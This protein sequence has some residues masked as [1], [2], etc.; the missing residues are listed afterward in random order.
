MIGDGGDAFFR[1]IVDRLFDASDGRRVD[2]DVIARMGAQGGDQQA[3][4]L[5][6][7]FALLHQV[8]KIGAVEALDVFVWLMQLKLRQNILTNAASCAGGEGGDRLIGKAGAQVAQLTVLRSK[9]MAPFGDAVRL[10][11]SEEPNG[12]AMQPGDCFRFG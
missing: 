1:E 7:V 12:D 3:R 9:F 10:V 2:D 6:A 4:L 8:A 11:D 5:A